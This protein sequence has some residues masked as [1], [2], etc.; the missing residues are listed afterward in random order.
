MC[1]M[2]VSDLT[3]PEVRLWSSWSL[4]AQHTT[5]CMLSIHCV[6]QQAQQS[7]GVYNHYS[8][9]EEGDIF[10]NW[11]QDSKL[12]KVFNRSLWNKLGAKLRSCDVR[13]QFTSGGAFYSSSS[14]VPVFH[15]LCSFPPYAEGRTYTVNHCSV[16]VI[17][18][19]AVNPTT[20]WS[21]S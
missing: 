13:F 6:F 11:P 1:M 3:G 16:F 20:D 9:E 19:G 2:L 5:L 4:S 17:L 18:C 14:L 12:K 7:G 10:L 21:V 15:Q 8:G